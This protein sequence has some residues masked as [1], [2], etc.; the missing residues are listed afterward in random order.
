MISE[1]FGDLVETIQLTRTMPGTYVNGK[2]VSAG[3]QTTESILAVVV[4]LSA[5]QLANNIAPVG[6]EDRDA[7]SIY[8]DDNLL[9]SDEE[10]GQNRDTITWRGKQY[11]IKSVANRYQIEDLAHYHSIAYLKGS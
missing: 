5:S 6:F 4:P 8:S 3:G 10:S 11:V 2:F 7:I 9:E 1:I